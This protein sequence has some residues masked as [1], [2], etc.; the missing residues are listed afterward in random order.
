MLLAGSRK[1][2]VVWALATLR[3]WVFQ[4]IY[5]INEISLG[6]LF[7]FLCVLLLRVVILFF[8]SKKILAFYI[9]FELRLIPT[10]LMVFFFGYQPE[11]L[12]AAIYLLIYTVFSSLPLL[13]LFLNLSGYLLFLPS[14]PAF[15]LAGFLTLGFMVK[16]P[17]YLVHV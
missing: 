12:R 11:K 1:S 17:I 5:T 2:V 10:L 14:A 7:H 6:R 9:L 4:H 16:T 8:L 15:W 13:L 3:F